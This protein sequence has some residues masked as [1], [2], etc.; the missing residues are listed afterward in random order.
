MICE[1]YLQHHDSIA[2]YEPYFSEMLRFLELYGY[3]YTH[4]EGLEMLLARP[5]I[6]ALDDGTT[7][8]CCSGNC[9]RTL[10]EFKPDEA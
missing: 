10:I 6:I 8:I 1:Y 9:E 5:R 2:F 3:I 4:E 7:E